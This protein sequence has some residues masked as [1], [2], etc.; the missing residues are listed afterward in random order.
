[1]EPVD[2][3]KRGL[4]GDPVGQKGRTGQIRWV[5]F[6]F[7]ICFFDEGFYKNFTKHPVFVILNKRE[8]TWR[9]MREKRSF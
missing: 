9:N 8:I 7:L 5:L 2:P 1:M 3:G 6:A 4:A